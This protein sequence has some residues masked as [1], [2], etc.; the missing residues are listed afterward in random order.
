MGG[1]SGVL[2]CGGGVGLACFR[3][4]R[5]YL[6]GGRRVECA[7]AEG[8]LLRRAL[9]EPAEELIGRRFGGRMEAE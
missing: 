6:A 1:S 5:K 2:G 9:L 4:P 3:P 7:Q 8:A